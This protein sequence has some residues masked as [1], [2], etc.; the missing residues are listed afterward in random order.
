MLKNIVT[1]RF[2]EESGAKTVKLKKVKLKEKESNEDI[3]EK[4][5]E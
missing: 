4:T 1:K 5:E 3:P 2:G